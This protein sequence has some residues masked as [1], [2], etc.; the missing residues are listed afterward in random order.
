MFLKSTI[1]LTVTALVIGFTQ[2]ADAQGNWPSKPVIVMV[3]F[4]AGGNADVLGRIFAEKLGNRLGQQFVIENRVGAGG[5]TGIAA[6]VKAPPDGYT[7]GV[8]TASGLAINMHLFKDKMPFNAER[9]VRP[10]MIMGTQ[11]NILVV[12]PSIPAKTLPELI[13]YLKANPDKESYGSSG[14]GTSI[15]ICME[16]IANQTGIKVG[17][18]AYRASNQIM[19]DIVGGQIK[20][21]CDNASTALPQVKEG[22][23]RAIA[24]TSPKRYAHLPEV[25]TVAETLPGFDVLT[26]HSYIAPRAMPAEIG[27]RLI[28]ELLEIGKEPDV[29]AKLEA[30][31][32]ES[33]SVAGAAFEAFMQQ[34]QVYYGGVI[35]KAGIK[36]P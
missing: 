10:L 15:H 32:V 4:A 31:G 29:R 2:A 9:D 12:H 3:P 14:I 17:H 7:I 21:T 28:K 33:S 11:P 27:D 36:I 30:L 6:M 20:I 19:Q 16:I 34:Q 13:D 26:W 8:G 18:V 25:P 1:C 24:V 22:K 35:E 23:L 5:N